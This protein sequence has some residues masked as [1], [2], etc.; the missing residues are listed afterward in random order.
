MLL[1]PL[2]PQP[3][4]A[5]AASVGWMCFLS[6]E[7]SLAVRCELKNVDIISPQTQAPECGCRNELSSPDFCRWGHFPQ[8]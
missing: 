7:H 4:L 1:T 3:G 2:L 6:S 5:F 8:S